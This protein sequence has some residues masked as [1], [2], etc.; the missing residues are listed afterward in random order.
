MWLRPIINICIRS[1]FNDFV[2][3]GSYTAPNDWMVV[4]YMDV[5]VAHFKSQTGHF[6]GWTGEN[7]TG[8][9]HACNVP[10]YV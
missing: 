4:Y 1:I 7:Y 9:L 6:S 3:N 5:I 8:F 10:A 2:S